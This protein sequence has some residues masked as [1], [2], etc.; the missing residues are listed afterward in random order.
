[1]KGHTAVTYLVPYGPEKPKLGIVK[2]AETHQVDIFWHAPFGQFK[3]YQLNIEKMSNH[4]SMELSTDTF[5]RAGK[6]SCDTQNTKSSAQSLSSSNK[7]Q[8]EILI[9]ERTE[10]TI[11]DLEP[12]E[13][14][15]VRLF[16]KNGKITSNGYISDVILTKPL[17][18]MQQRAD[19]I[20][21][22]SFLLTWTPPEIHNCLVGF[23]IKVLSGSEEVESITKMRKANEI[24]EHEI[25]QLDP[26]KDYDVLLRSV[27]NAEGGKRTESIPSLL[28]VTTSLE[29]VKN[30]QLS[31]STTGSI[32]IRWDPPKENLSLKYTLVIEPYKDT[33]IW[34]NAFQE[35]DSPDGETDVS[36]VQDS[37][38]MD[39]IDDGKLH[40]TP[41]LDEQIKIL[42]TFKQRHPNITV[43]EHKYEFTE[44][45]VG[46]LGSGYPYQ[47]S[48]FA[49]GKSR[50][51]NDIRSG[52]TKEIFLTRPHP[53]TDIKP[54]EFGIKWVPS[55][56]T[57]V[58][59]YNIRWKVEVPNASDTISEEEDTTVLQ[60]EDNNNMDIQFQFPKSTG[61]AKAGVGCMY[62]VKLFAIVNFKSLS[63]KARSH[64]TSLRLTV[65]DDDKMDLHLDEQSTLVP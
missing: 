1:M 61:N 38:G 52:E 6:L 19:E 53:P 47:I 2:E 34:R 36:E 62:H 8:I 58:T 51:G 39:Y 63:K 26:G 64:E 25:T 40:D 17:P 23:D 60:R 31:K 27:C 37:A 29:K 15:L 45:P 35:C 55:I 11:V 48:I 20:L 16:T 33:E 56:T 32:S 42:K 3:K 22:H 12:G 10:Y 44:L 13:R 49:S 65:N 9:T 28:A 7:R 54:Y 4:A 50:Q 30:I 18:P 59:E 5:L 46:P 24:N 14:Y 57:H 21:P 41:S 43:S